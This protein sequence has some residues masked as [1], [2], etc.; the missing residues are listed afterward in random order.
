[1]ENG[2]I[3]IKNTEY[4]SDIY[5]YTLLNKNVKF[6][7]ILSGENTN[8]IK[9]AVLN[10]AQNKNELEILDPGYLYFD[11]LT[12]D[13][14]TNIKKESMDIKQILYNVNGLTPNTTLAFWCYKQGTD[15]T[16]NP[17]I[18]D[19]NYVTRNGLYVSP[20]VI[21]MRNEPSEFIS[22]RWFSIDTLFNNIQQNIRDNHWILYFYQFQHHDAM[23]PKWLNLLNNQS[24]IL[25][26]VKNNPQIGKM[27][28]NVHAVY[29]SNEGIIHNILS[30]AQIYKDISLD[31]SD[32][33]DYITFNIPMIQP[34][35]NLFIGGVKIQNVASAIPTDGYSLWNGG[36]RNMILFNT[37]LTHEQMCNLYRKSIHNLYT[38]NLM[39][40][41]DNILAFKQK[42]YIGS[43]YTYNSETITVKGCLLKQ[44]IKQISSD[45]FSDS[46]I[47]ILKYNIKNIN[48][49]NN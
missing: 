31:S 3:Q 2:E 28:I 40:E 13:G 33:T 30:P 39:N 37:F 23:Q 22:D 1:M 26:S 29:Q 17:I 27:K 44:N 38:W 49:N 18:S 19:Y 46:E 4:L 12:A 45:I 36:I 41:Y 48:V 35:T 5:T 32:Y 6:N 47:G 42:P 20:S 14:N 7:T 25:D 34:T 11:T 43:V 10:T 8:N 16:N 21:K 15:Y 24:N 9:S